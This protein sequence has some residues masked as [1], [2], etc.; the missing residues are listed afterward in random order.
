MWATFLFF[1]RVGL[2]TGL[3]SFRFLFFKFANF[4]LIEDD[5]ALSS[6]SCSFRYTLPA[7]AH[8]VAFCSGEAFFSALALENV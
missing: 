7:R 1:E 6:V 5:T 3:L 8:N 2:L 4:G